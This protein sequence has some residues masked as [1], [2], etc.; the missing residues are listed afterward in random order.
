MDGLDEVGREANGRFAAGFSGNPAGKCPGTRN[1]AT[2]LAV[3]LAEGESETIARVVIDKALAGDAVAARFL[4]DRL[5]PKP[6][7]RAITLELP[8]GESAGGDVVAMFNSALRALA[9]GEITPDEAVTVSRFL[10]GRSR[11]LKA[12]ELERKLTRWDHQPPIPGDDVVPEADSVGA[13]LAPARPRDPSEIGRGQAPPLRDRADT[14][15]GQDLLKAGASPARHKI[16]YS[17]PAIHLH[18]HK[19]PTT[20]CDD[21]AVDRASCFAEHPGT[22]RSRDDRGSRILKRDPR[23]HSDRERNAVVQMA[24]PRYSS[25]LMRCLRGRK[26]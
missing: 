11:V 3:A 9:A 1:R 14:P 8:D 18:R 25:N 24:R 5:N 4:L 22:V 12:W 26:R 6:R 21:V 23:A 20:S 10:E 2:L 13:G 19:G 15:A 17:S 16:L 7:G